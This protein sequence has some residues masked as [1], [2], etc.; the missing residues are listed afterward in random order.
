MEKLIIVVYHIFYILCVS[1][2]AFELWILM[3][4]MFESVRC[5]SVSSGLPMR[6][7]FPL[8]NSRRKQHFVLFSA[9]AIE[10]M[11]EPTQK[12]SHF[13]GFSVGVC[14]CCLEGLK[15]LLD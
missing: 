4:Q 6:A 8:E 1:F 13:V 14:E 10:Q 15:Q 11:K 9:F 3:L 12:C 5:L 7:F 2:G